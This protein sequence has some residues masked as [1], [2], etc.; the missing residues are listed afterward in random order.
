MGLLFNEEVKLLGTSIAQ[1]VKTFRGS[2]TLRKYTETFNGETTTKYSLQSTCYVYLNPTHYNTSNAK[3]IAEEHY[4][5]HLDTY[6][7]SDPIQ[8]LYDKLKEGFTDY[9]DI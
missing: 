1:I 3:P 7:A 6:P 5:I 4:N 8:M 9:Q 2:Y